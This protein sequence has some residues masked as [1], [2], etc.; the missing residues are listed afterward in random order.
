MKKG[1][2]KLA[3]ILLLVSLMTTACGNRTEDFIGR[4]QKEN[5]KMFHI[6]QEIS[7]KEQKKLS[8]NISMEE[9]MSNTVDQFCQK[10]CEAVKD[11]KY[12]KYLIDSSNGFL[13]LA[14]DRETVLGG[15]ALDLNAYARDV[16]LGAAKTGKISGQSDLAQQGIYG[17]QVFM[18]CE[19][20]QK[21]TAIK[22]DNC[23]FYQWK[24]KILPC[25]YVALTQD[26]EFVRAMKSHGLS[27]F[28]SMLQKEENK[29]WEH[30][31]NRETTDEYL[32]INGV[33][34]GMKIHLGNVLYIVQDT[35]YR[36]QRGTAWLEKLRG[37]DAWGIVR[38]SH[39]KKC[40]VLVYEMSLD[41]IWSGGAEYT[42]E[43][44]GDAEKQTVEE[45]VFSVKTQGETMTDYEFPLCLKTTLVNYL[46]EMG[47][48]EGKVQRLLQNTP[49]DE[50]REG[51]VSYACKREG[52]SGYA[53][54]IEW[55]F[56]HN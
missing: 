24:E 52:E 4:M 20:Y 10:F 15:V 51:Q 55:C 30:P 11:T 43:I 1:N 41:G 9:P 46:K 27:W 17:T 48:K 18:A 34:R 14:E 25:Y 50:G 13:E 32:A 19:E 31:D 42:M 8:C 54:E 40:D 28:V 36:I 45:V 5:T 2:K 23:I 21:G 39:G 53:Q 56:W 44:Y 47:M 35:N 3:G 38:A 29:I 16:F 12:G 26:E 22:A 49:G 7:E 37:E 6:E 33:F